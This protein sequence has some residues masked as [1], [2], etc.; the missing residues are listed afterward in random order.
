MSK[1]QATSITDVSF[2]FPDIQTTLE[3]LTFQAGYNSSIVLTGTSLLGLAAGVVGTF[4]LLRK[5]ALIG[6]ALAH[7][8]LPGL[9]SAYLC[10][11]FLNLQAKSLPILLGGATLSGILGVLTVQFLIRNT[12]LKEDTAIGVVLSVFFG[13]GV[14]LMSIIQSL[15]TGSEG[16]LD[17]FIYGQT[18][19][20]SSSDAYLTLILA[21]LA[22]TAAIFLLKEFRLVCFDPE[23]ATVQGWPV[24][25]IDLMMMTLIVLVTVIGLQTVGIILIIALLIIPASAARFWSESFNKVTLLSGCFGAL[26]GYLGGAAS[27]LLPRLPAGSIIVLTAGI[28]FTISFFFA[29]KRGIIAG[30]YRLMKLRLRVAEDHFLRETFELMEKTGNS[31][32][33]VS[34]LK[35]TRGFSLKLRT[36]LF[37]RVRS[38]IKRLGPKSFELSKQGLI[39]AKALTRNHRLWEEYVRSYAQV[40]TSHVDYSADLVEHVLTQDIVTELEKGLDKRSLLREEA[41]SIHPLEAP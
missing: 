10:A 21:I 9:A 40:A 26:S 38:L 35:V 23:Y 28:I 20:L 7:S 12:R 29:P 14:V 15:G 36:L 2:D 11:V 22:T 33:S 6:D 19:A 32:I 37:F 24:S 3:V 4:S 17:H 34:D 18:A 31:T 25:A 1:A 5:R 41:K 8:A 13:F 30:A 27:A 39:K 16:G